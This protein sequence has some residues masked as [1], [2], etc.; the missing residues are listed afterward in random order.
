MNDALFIKAL[1]LLP[2]NAWSRAVGAAAHAGLRWDT[3]GLSYG[4]ALIQEDK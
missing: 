4:Q 2:K 3:N 1:R